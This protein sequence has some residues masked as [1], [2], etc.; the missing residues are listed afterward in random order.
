MKDYLKDK[1]V[2]G[3][4]HLNKENLP[5]VVLFNGKQ[6]EIRYTFKG[7]IYMRG[8]DP[9]RTNYTNYIP[10]EPIDIAD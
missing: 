6:Y 2:K 1:K 3:V 7:S 9:D 8:Y 4:L 10:E 5:I